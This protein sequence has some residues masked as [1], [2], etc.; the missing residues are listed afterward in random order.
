MLLSPN[1][2]V[3]IDST[4]F[5]NPKRKSSSDE[6]D[7]GTSSH[8]PS[9]PVEAPAQRHNRPMSLAPAA[10]SKRKLTSFKRSTSVMLGLDDR[11]NSQ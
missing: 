3:M 10:Y 11:V 4:S 6:R 5:T 8:S 7:S 2:F 9:S 1:A